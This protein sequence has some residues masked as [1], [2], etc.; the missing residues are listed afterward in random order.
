MR[1]FSLLIAS[2]AASFVSASFADEIAVV[3]VFSGHDPL[4]GR[5]DDYA[6][7]NKECVEANSKARDLPVMTIEVFAMAENRVKCTAYK[8]PK[9]HSD[10][11]GD[12][13]TFENKATFKRP[14]YLSSLKCVETDRGYDLL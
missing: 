2:T 1:L 13:Y 12:K 7:E 4:Y 10:G 9:C 6:F 5:Q 8:N 14:F 11:P 3:T